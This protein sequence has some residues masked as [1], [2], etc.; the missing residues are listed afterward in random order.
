MIQHIV[1]FRF[2]GTEP[3]ETI[4]QAEQAKTRLEALVGMVPDI[5][6][7]VVGIDRSAAAGHWH[8]VLVSQ[9]VSQ[10]ALDAYQVHPDHAAA[11]AFVGQLTAERAVVDYQT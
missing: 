1:S 9:F 4:A 3:G 7:L 10:R 2:T 6:S 11:A 5:A 8:A